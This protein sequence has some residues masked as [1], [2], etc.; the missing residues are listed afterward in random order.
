M[1][2]QTLS[3]IIATAV[4][5]ALAQTGQ[6]APAAPV[7]GSPFAA[8]AL[9]SGTGKAS[10]IPEPLRGASQKD[11][12]RIAAVLAIPGWSCTVDA[13][14]AV[15]GEDGTRVGAAHGFAYAHKP[16]EPCKGVRGV[17]KGE[18]CPGVVRG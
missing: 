4:E 15:P 12:R 3:A 8:A 17:P 5:A 6:S 13:E 16:G 2:A 7:A 18:T 14:Y 10:T 9:V 11:A 1:D